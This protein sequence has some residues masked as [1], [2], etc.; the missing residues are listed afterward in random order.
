MVPIYAVYSWLSY[1]FYREAVYYQLIQT[2]YEGFVI[3]SFFIL[4]VNYIGEH[5]EDQRKAM[6]AKKGQRFKLP[7]PLNC[8]TVNPASPRF[9]W[10]LKIGILQY[11]IIRPFN[12]LL[13]IVLLQEN[14]LSR[15]F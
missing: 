5:P 12:T 14:L 3:A 7:I 10:W 6:L 4:L 9:L 13:A 15:E 1:I 2:S 11:A 8:F